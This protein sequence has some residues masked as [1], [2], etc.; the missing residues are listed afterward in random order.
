MGGTCLTRGCIPSKVLV[1]PADLI[2]ESQ[3][4]KK[5]GIKFNIENIDWDLIAERMWSQ[6]DENKMI[7]K[8]L[9]NSAESDSYIKGVGEFVGEYEMKVK[10]NKNGKE[11]GHFK[12]ERF[13]IASGARSF[14]PPIQGIKDMD[15]ITNENFFGDRFPKKPWK[16]LIIIGGGVIAAEFAHIFS[17]MGTNVTI[18]EMLPRLVVRV[19]LFMEING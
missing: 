13:I 11:L 17:A 6:I 14:I 16:S 1:H 5:V 12:A 4:A 18:V 2:R 19:N 3:H 7:D 8:G 15:Y 9:I 10:D